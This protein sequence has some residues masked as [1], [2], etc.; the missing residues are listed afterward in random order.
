MDK[1]GIMNISDHK[2]F[3]SPDDNLQISRSSLTAS[4]KSR[5][6]QDIDINRSVDD[7]ELKK[8]IQDMAGEELSGSLLSIGERMQFCRELFSSIRGLDI[9]QEIL[10]DDEITEIM[11]NGADN[12]FIEK[13]GKLSRY[14]GVFSSADRLNDVIQSIVG[15]ANKRVNESTPIVDTRLPDGS[16]VN[17]VLP[18]VSINGATVTI[19]KFP[20]KPI[21]MSDLLSFGS[22]SQEAANFLK[23]LVQCGFNIFISGGT[24]SGKTTFLNALSDFI[25]SSERIITIEDSA[26]LQIRHID[27]LVSLECRPANTEGENEIT[28]RDLIRSSLRMR[29]TRIIVGEVRGAESF[30]M[31]QAMNT[32]HDGS[33][34]TGH[35]NST[36]DMLTRLEM[37]VLTAADMPLPAIRSQIASA[38]DIMV[39]LSRM[40]DGSRKV[41]EISEVAGIQ[42]GQI[43]LTPLFLYN[44]ETGL[45]PTGNQLIN[46]H[47]LDGSF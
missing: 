8:L 18:P 37:M 7:E 32:G 5:L 15:Q 3:L 30:D 47:K 21:T 46:T 14:N 27:N 24:G 45:A 12:I 42:D 29:P 4:L 35:A 41:V 17:V 28:I 39:H 2:F 38:L 40:R 34:S 26:E 23:K 16:R 9:L 1:T 10:D 36:K 13:K 19:R 43:K 31:L 6:I 33:L 22:I 11:V 20:K 44:P 25:P